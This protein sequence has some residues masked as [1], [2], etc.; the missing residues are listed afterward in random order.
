MGSEIKIPL[1]TEL[2][3]FRND[4]ENFVR[5]MVMKLHINRHKGFAESA[6]LDSLLV[7][8]EMETAEL[9]RA[10]EN[11]SQFEAALEA[12]DVANM[13]F[14]FALKCFQMTK[15]DYKKGQSDGNS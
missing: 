8:I 3:P 11:E 5:L 6:D 10:R 1:T 12:V 15:K 14:L 4:L 9:Q 2:E 13:S 7:G